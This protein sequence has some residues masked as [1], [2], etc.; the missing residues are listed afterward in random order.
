MNASDQFR[1]GLKRAS[2]ATGISERQA[3]L[4]A[5]CNENQLNRFIKHSTDIKLTTLDKICGDGFGMSFD[6]VYRMGK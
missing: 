2:I 3:C 1:A 4:E 6:T 5:G